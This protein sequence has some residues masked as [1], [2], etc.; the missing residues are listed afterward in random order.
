MS[1]SRTSFNEADMYMVAKY[2]VD[3]PLFESATNSERWGPFGE[4]V[5]RELHSTY[6]LRTDPEPS[7]PKGQTNPGQSTSV[8][9]KR[10]RRDDAV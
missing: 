7:I 4:R 2:I 1:E 8:G 9:M 5:S 6:A 3:F 10:V